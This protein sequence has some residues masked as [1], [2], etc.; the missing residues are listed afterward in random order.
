MSKVKVYLVGFGPGDPDLMTV[1]SHKLLNQ[2]DIV[3]Y[4][5]LINNQILNTLKC[6]CVYVGKRKGKHSKT[7]DEINELLYQASL[8]YITI[9]RLKGGDP[10]IFG[11]GGEELIFLQQKNVSVE[12]IPGVTASLAAAASVK[13]PLTMR[14]IAKSLTFLA[15]HNID[16]G[17]MDIPVSDTLVFYM[18]ASKLAELI[19]KNV[20]TKL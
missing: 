16:K 8:K 3:F 19:S 10:F 17:D 12:I 5:D 20:I 1:K 9:I 15:A 14:H 11:R 2:A 13:I 7:Q 4:D 18:G 6:P